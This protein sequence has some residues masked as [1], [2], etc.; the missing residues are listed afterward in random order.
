[1][2]VKFIGEF[3]ELESGLACIAEQ[4]GITRSE[5]GIPIAVRTI[6][7]GLEVE[8]SNGQ[9]FIGYEKKHHFF[10]ALSL[11]AEASRSG[12]QVHKKELQQFRSIG[13]MFDS[14]RNGVFRED[15]L[16]Q[17]LRHMAL[18][19]MDRLLIYMEDT[20]ELPGKPYFG[21]FRSKY[22]FEELKR[23]DDYAHDLGIEI[24]PVIQSLGH[25]HQVLKWRADPD[26]VGTDDILLVGSDRTYEFIEEMMIHASAP[27]RSK[28]IHLGMDEAEQVGLGNYL[29][30]HGYRDRFEIL[31]THLSRVLEIADKHE[32]KPMIWSDMY[33]KMAS[34]TQADY[35][36]L[37]TEIPKRVLE[38]M[39]KNVKYVYWDYY[40]HDV[41]HYRTMIRKHKEI[42]DDTVF[43]GGIWTFVGTSVN[44]DKTFDASNKALRACKEEGVKEVFATVWG[45]NGAETNYFAALPGMQ[46]FAEH[47]YSPEPEVDAT[48]LR[49]RFET[50]TGASLDAFLTLNEV[51]AVPGAERPNLLPS[52]PSK[53]LLWQDVLAGLFDKHVE[54]TDL[55][56]HYSRL[57]EELRRHGEQHPEWRLLFDQ[58]SGLC[59]V[60][61]LKAH[62][63]ERLK[64]SYDRRDLPALR[65]MADRLLPELLSKVEGLRSAHR[66]LWFHTYKPLGWEILD[67]RYGGVL[68]RIRTA[69]WRIE[70]FAEG[71]VDRLEELE[72]ERLFFDPH[73]KEET[74]FQCMNSYVRIVSASDL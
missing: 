23:C 67:I 72:V 12:A 37:D 29:K 6:P 21:Y 38:E 47:A 33:F 55:T 32:L 20:F 50:C 45:D 62:A 60:L 27:F 44:Y 24:I 14:S 17:L 49:D 31:T 5:A 57:K 19:G 70:Q 48:S 18:M 69:I 51:D 13:V 74:R 56:G 46:L 9:G 66:D 1:L 35:W 54:G 42:S 64:Q 8:F 73:G 34:V 43:A 30:K 10:R 16:K 68:A 41:E 28:K 65:E 15:R 4:L 7:A 40:H 39:P 26:I 3:R 61:R 58:A 53:M 22:G 52:A 71:K 63:G 36:N 2:D 11:L 25:L 59:D